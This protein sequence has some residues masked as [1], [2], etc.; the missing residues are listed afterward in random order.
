MK[1]LE[2]I[3]RPEDYKILKENKEYMEKKV[4]ELKNMDITKE[5]SFIQNDMEAT[6]YSTN[7][8]IEGHTEI[9]DEF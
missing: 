7:F 4:E 1:N 6:I 3:L 9:L 5:M 8:N 2:K